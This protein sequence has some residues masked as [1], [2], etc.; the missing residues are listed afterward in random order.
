MLTEVQ[1]LYVN[2]QESEVLKVEVACDLFPVFLRIALNQSFISCPIGFTIRKEINAHESDFKVMLSLTHKFPGEGCEFHKSNN[3]NMY[4]PITY[5]QKVELL[6]YK[7]RQV[8]FVFSE[9]PYPEEHVYL[10][11]GIAS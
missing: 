8:K 6:P 1:N 4:V 9:K 7:Q 3:E 10:Y 5:E 11:V 2:L